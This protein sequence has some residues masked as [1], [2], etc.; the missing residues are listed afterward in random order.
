MSYFQLEMLEKSNPLTAEGAKARRKVRKELKL[1]VLA[2]R[3]LQHLSVL[4]G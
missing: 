1:C 3:S 4:C 2:L